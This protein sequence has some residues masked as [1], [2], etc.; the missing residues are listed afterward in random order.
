MGLRDRRRHP[1]RATAALATMSRRRHGFRTRGIRGWAARCGRA[2]LQLGGESFGAESAR[3][4][5]FPAWSTMAPPHGPHLEARHLERIRPMSGARFAARRRPG[6][7]AMVLVAGPRHA[8][9][10]HL[11]AD[12]LAHHPGLSARHRHAH[13]Q[14]AALGERHGGTGRV[15]CR[16][17]RCAGPGQRRGPIR[18][19]GRRGR[20]SVRVTFHYAGHATPLYR[21]F[22]AKIAAGEKVPSRSGGR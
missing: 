14:P 10:H 22:S 19:H 21:D 5:A 20:P 12:D 7:G 4:L 1:L 18:Y 17:D 8:R 2:V 11:R 13:P 6:A 15:P 16:A 9:R 3:T